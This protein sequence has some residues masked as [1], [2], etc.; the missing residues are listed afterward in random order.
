MNVQVFEW[1]SQKCI[2]RKTLYQKKDKITADI[3]AMDYKIK[4]WEYYDIKIKN[5]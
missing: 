1:Y 5:I 4:F 3:I 2:K